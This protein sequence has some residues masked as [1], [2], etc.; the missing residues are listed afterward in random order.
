MELHVR[1]WTEDIG[2]EKG[3]DTEPEGLKSLWAEQ[4]RECW[5]GFKGGG[6]LTSQD[7]MQWIRRGSGYHWRLPVHTMLWKGR[8][9]DQ[10]TKAETPGQWEEGHIPSL[11]HQPN[12]LPEERAPIRLHEEVKGSCLILPLKL[13]IQLDGAKVETLRERKFSSFSLSSPSQS[14]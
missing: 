6:H 3:Q 8:G 10:K 11:L 2:A 12:P 5:S 7:W 14:Y 4:S 1:D 9:K 13:L